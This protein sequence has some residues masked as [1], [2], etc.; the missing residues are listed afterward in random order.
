MARNEK[1]MTSLR[2][3]RDRVPRR[4]L[5]ST[6]G[7]G[8][9]IECFQVEHGIP[10]LVTLRF[11]AGVSKRKNDLVEDQYDTKVLVGASTL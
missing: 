5:K 4:V 9:G 8:I 2:V 7:C 3:S 1:F 10:R 11:L 6:L